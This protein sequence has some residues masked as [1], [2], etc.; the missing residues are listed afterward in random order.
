[1]ANENQVNPIV[2][3]NKALN[4]SRMLGVNLSNLG[5]RQI[6]G[7]QKSQFVSRLKNQTTARPKP[8]RKRFTNRATSEFNTDHKAVMRAQTLSKQRELAQF[9]ENQT[10]LSENTAR[11]L[12][13]LRKTQNLSRTRD[14][15]QQRRNRERRIVA[16]AMDLMKTPFIFAHSRMDFTGVPEDNILNAKNVFKEDKKNNPN[17]LTPRRYSV[18]DTGKTGFRL[19]F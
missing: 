16:D 6:K 19:K 3:A 12:A 14:A 8:L 18:L 15:E 5:A 9:R 1:M 17:I 7:I 13:D 4:S 10:H 11:L 2:T